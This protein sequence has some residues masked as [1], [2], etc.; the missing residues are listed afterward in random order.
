MFPVKQCGCYLLWVKFGVQR[1]SI[2]R[3]TCCE[4]D[5]FIVLAHLQDELFTEGSLEHINV[6]YFPIYFYWLH[7]IRIIYGLE[8]GMN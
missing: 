6:L 8:R 5:N 4:H 1:F 7:N 3:Q 2:L